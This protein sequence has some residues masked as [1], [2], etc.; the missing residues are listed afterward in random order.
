MK[1]FEFQFLRRS[2]RRTAAPVQS[3]KS[4]SASSVEMH[5]AESVLL[6]EGTIGF[7]DENLAGSV[8]ARHD[9]RRLDRLELLRH[10]PHGALK[11]FL[12]NQP[13]AATPRGHK[14]TNKRR[15]G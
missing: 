5:A 15:D 10:L 14:I 11:A 7:L 6:E 12:E 3:P 2:R 13:A 9:F 1:Y 4:R 8:I